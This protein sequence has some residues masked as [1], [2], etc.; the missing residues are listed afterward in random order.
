MM[1]RSTSRLQ[2]HCGLLVVTVSF[3]LLSS[4][5]TICN[6][7]ESH[8][9]SVNVADPASQRAG[10]PVVGAYYYPW[11]GVNDRPLEHDWD[12]VM[13]RKLAPSQAPLAGL[14]RSDDP[15]VISRHIEQSKRAGIDFWAVSW[16]GPDTATDRTI[17]DSILKHPDADQLRYAI[18]YEATGRLGSFDNPD[19]RHLVDDFAYLEKTYFS[20]ANY[21]HVDDKP[22]VFIYLTREYFRN[23]G[24]AELAALR[25]RVKNVFI[26]GDDVFGGE[27]RPEWAKQFDAVTSYDIYGQSTSQHQ[28]TIKAVEALASNYANARRAAN[29]VGTAFIPAVAPG[30]NDTAERPGHPGTA[31][32][33]INDSNSK[34]G[35]LFR[36]MIRQAAL[37]HLDSACGRLMMVTSFNEWY[38]DSQIEPTVGNQP[39]TLQDSSESGSF[40]T[41]G[42]RYADYGPLYL[43]I[44]A[45][46]IRSRRSSAE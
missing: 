33:I 1:N 6:A 15:Q 9:A 23:R 30:Y 12:H 24:H 13:R 18:L 46:E 4:L 8:E 39:A 32:Y 35:D 22:V 19:Y 40:Y 27:Y 44:L 43:D 20:D 28:A 2:R 10:A 16:W 34:E 17:R 31:R 25:K 41:M 42:D 29:S 45:E 36:A 37:P 7:A 11:Y 5:V 26:V 21:L 14:Y 38:E 3:G